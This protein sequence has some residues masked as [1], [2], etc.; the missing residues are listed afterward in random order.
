[1]TILRNLWQR[2]WQRW[3]LTCGCPACRLQ[4]AVDALQADGTL[5][6]AVLTHAGGLVSFALVRAGQPVL[7][8][9]MLPAMAR[10]VGR[11]LVRAANLTEQAE[12]AAHN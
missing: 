9:P 12:H 10:E 8:Y 3:R 7:I 1:M 2:L 6:A 5:D 4:R 11:G